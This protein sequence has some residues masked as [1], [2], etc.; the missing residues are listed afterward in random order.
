MNT[1]SGMALFQT[2]FGVCGIAWTVAGIRAV[3]LPAGTVG[4][5]RARLA[6]RPGTPGVERLPPDDVADAIRRIQAMLAGS[7]DALLE[8]AVDLDGVAPFRRDVYAIVRGIPPGQT[9]TYGAIA[10][11]LGAPREAAQRVGQV[12]GSNPVPLIVPCHR[13][14][15]AGGKLGGFSAPGG[16]ATKRRLLEMEGAIPPAPRDLFGAPATT[17]PKQA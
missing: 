6:R 8:L 5:T 11:R 1:G 16:A 7:R 12:M 14:L 3:Q 2:A 9:L 13:V 15:A 17:S 4:A 10:G